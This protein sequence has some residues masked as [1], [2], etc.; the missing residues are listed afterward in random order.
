[1]SH[2]SSPECGLEHATETFHVG[3][4][5]ALGMAIE[6]IHLI[7]LIEHALKDIESH[8]DIY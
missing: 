1:M 8:T 6:A 4:S 7:K 3:P 2:L 5:L